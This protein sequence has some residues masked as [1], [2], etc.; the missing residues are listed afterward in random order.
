MRIQLSD[1]FTYPKLLRFVLPSIIMMICTSIYSIV[2]GLFVSNYVGKTPFAAVNLIFPALM[3]MGTVGFMIGTGGSAIVAKTLGQGDRKNANRYFSMLIYTA[4]IFGAALS[5]PGFIFIRPISIA[6]GATGEMIDYCVL[7]GRILIAGQTAFILQNVFQSFF[8]VAEKP[9]LSLALSIAA[10][11]TNFV[12][13]FL[14]IAVFQWGLAGAAVAT[15]TGQAVGGIIPLIYFARKNDSLLRLTRT[16]LEG[17]ILLRA[18]GNGSSEM[19][20]NLSASL[21]NILYNFQLIKLAG[22]DGVAAYGAIMYVCFIFAAIFIGY[23][24]GSAPV[25]SYH[26]GAGNHD[27]LKNLFRK[28]LILIGACSV[29]M[30]LLAELLASPLTK[31]FVGYD[32]ALHAMT[33]WGFRL[34][35]I[36]FL[37]SGVNAFGSAFFTALN[38]GVVSAVISFM[39]TLVFQCVVILVLPVFLKLDGVWLSLPLAETLSLAVTVFF[40][41][42]KRNQYHYA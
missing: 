37:L 16:R 17:R 29:A 23:S 18:C 40:F 7:Y 36:S 33:C 14:F 34:Y 30:T 13:D 5:V 39:R 25:I 26:Y 9:H 38:N 21:V 12:L 20:T 10:G 22:E 32:S 8:V 35:A 6:L 31:A 15:I 11:L 2:D 1:H 41:V 19:L 24:I 4:I 27:E 42:R 3:V 28:S